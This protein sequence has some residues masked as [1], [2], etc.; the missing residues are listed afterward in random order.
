MTQNRP[1]GR[2]R[3]RIVGEVAAYFD[4]M[5]SKARR[6]N[7]ARRHELFAW[8]SARAKR[9]LRAMEAPGHRDVRRAWRHAV[10]SWLRR[11]GLI[12]VSI[13]RN[14]VTPCSM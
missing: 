6:K 4:A 7:R 5:R 13:N 14:S 2:P 3:G 1:P 11:Q 9:T 8:I 12:E 10:E